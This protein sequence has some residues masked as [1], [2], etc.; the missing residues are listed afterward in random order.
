MKTLFQLSEAVEKHHVTAKSGFVY[1]WLD[2]KRKKYYLGSHMGTLSDGYTGSNKRFSYAHHLRPETFKRRIL[3]FYN[4]IADKDLRIREQLWLNLINDHDLHCEKYYNEKKVAFGGD[5][6]SLLPIEKR[7]QHAIKCGIASK[8][9]WDNI[10]PQD[11]EFRRKNAFGGNTFSREYLRERNKQLCSKFA[12]IIFPN[13]S[14]E[15]IKNVSEFCKIHNINYGNF[16]TV[17]RGERK[18]CNGFSGLYLELG[19]S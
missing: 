16:K 6:I 14:I 7:K 8:K 1:I 13:G 9:F 12:T 3:E 4:N 19:S 5:I 18:S 2:K 15:T 11:Y 17:L 10:T